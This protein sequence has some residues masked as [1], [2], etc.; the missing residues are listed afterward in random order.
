M[1]DIVEKFDEAEG[2]AEDDGGCVFGLGFVEGD[3]EGGEVGLDL[4]GF[5]VFGEE[6]AG[7]GVGP[8]LHEF[9]EHEGQAAVG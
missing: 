9:V 5:G 3:F 7:F 4:L 1:G 8:A 2:G 6:V